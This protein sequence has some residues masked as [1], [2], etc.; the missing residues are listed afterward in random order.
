MAVVFKTRASATHVVSDAAV[1][2]ETSLR[3]LVARYQ[4]PL[5][6]HHLVPVENFLLGERRFGYPKVKNSLRK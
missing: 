3:V 2:A 1:P 6:M 4:L 5:Q